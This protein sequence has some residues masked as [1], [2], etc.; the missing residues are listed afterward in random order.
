MEKY[1]IKKL[2]NELCVC[3]CVCVCVFSMWKLTLGYDNR[4][5]EKKT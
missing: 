5:Q 1:I 2:K 4:K 3:V